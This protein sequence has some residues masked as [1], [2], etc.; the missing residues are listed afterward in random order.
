MNSMREAN[1]PNLAWAR[2]RSLDWLSTV[3]TRPGGWPC[4]RRSATVFTMSAFAVPL[5]QAVEQPQAFGREQFDELGAIHP[6][7]LAPAPLGWHSRC[8]SAKSRID[9]L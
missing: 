8:T 4:L 2:C 3:A 7:T 9:S 6:A 1:G 5:G